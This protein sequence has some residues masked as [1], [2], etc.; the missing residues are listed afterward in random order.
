MI[1]RMKKQVLKKNIKLKRSAP[2]VFSCKVIKKDTQLCLDL[3]NTK[4]VVNNV[5]TTEQDEKEQIESAEQSVSKQKS[6]RK[7]MWN[8]IF[9]VLNIVVVSVIL[10]YQLSNENVTSLADL[11]GL[12]FYFL[13][14][15]MLMFVLIMFLDAYRTNLFMKRS[16]NRSRPYLCYKMCAVGK[17]YD[18]ITPMSSGGEPSQIFYLS[19]R[20]LGA[21]TSISVPMAR[22]VVSQISWMIIGI[23]AV[24]SI[25]FTGVMDVSVVLV[26]GLVGFIANFA[27]TSFCLLLSMSKK[28]GNKLVVKVLRLLQKIRIVKNYEKQYDRV[29]NVVEGYQKTMKTYAKNKLFFFYTILISIAIFVITYTIPFV[30]YLM[31]GG[32]DYSLWFNML[33]FS[34]IIELA[35]SIIPLPGGTG[36]NEISFSVIFASVF[37]N[38]TVFWGLLFWRFMTYYLFLIQ[39]IGIII[40]D[41]V[42]GNRKFKWLQRKWEL[43]TESILFQE[44]Q[45]KKYKKQQKKSKKL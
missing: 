10:F 41:Y 14:I 21:S 37:P 6:K 42:Y 19:H 2:F 11:R 16:I 32:T 24:I 8:A 40:Y 17:Y 20:G 4:L 35:S 18:N 26:V 15:L 45:I 9:F 28:L 44:D 1:V 43:E 5:Q 7:K 12:K 29:M 3:T 38:G 30:I 25:I 39:G 13:P 22:Y 23:V 27:L 34:V 31:F 36:M 33:V